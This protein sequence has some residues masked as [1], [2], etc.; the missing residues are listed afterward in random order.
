MPAVLTHKAITLLTRERLRRLHD[1]TTRL[2]ERKQLRGDM[3][4]AL[5]LKINRLS[6]QASFIMSAPPLV[7]ARTTQQRREFVGGSTDLFSSVSKFA[8]MG[9][10]GPDIPAFSHVFQPGQGWAFDTIHKGTPDYNREA[11]VAR[12]TDMA[13]SLHRIAEEK[14][15]SVF[16]DADISIQEQN[17]NR[18][19]AKVRAYVMGHLCHLA[20]DIVSHPFINDL[21]WHLGT[22]AHEHTAHGDNEKVIDVSV[23]SKIFRRPKIKNGQGWAEWWPSEDEIEPYFY[24]AYSEAFKDVYGAD[25]PE[26]FKDFE[27]ALTALGTPEMTP[28]FMK[29]GY[30]TFRGFI[31]NFAYSWSYWEWFALLTPLTALTAFAPLIS[32]GLP[33]GQELFGP[34]M[35]TFRCQNAPILS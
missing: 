5:E 22:D 8:V 23:S 1:A 29:H 13:L 9:S 34:K 30:R 15:R 18:E 12:T 2:I 10:M 27:D 33:H 31:L 7:D 28:E 6:R 3:V 16:S 4:S 32:Q 35:M 17:T 25:R 19:L 21:E 26:S 14:V 24:E 20:G 11:L